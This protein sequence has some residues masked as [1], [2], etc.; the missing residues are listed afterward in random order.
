ME[1]VELRNE[2]IR[3][4]TELYQLNLE[5][6]EDTVIYNEIVKKMRLC[7]SKQKAITKEIKKLEEIIETEDAYSTILLIEGTDML[8]KVEQIAISNGMDKTDYRKLGNY[9]RW[10]DLERLVKNTIKLK[11]QYPGW[12]LKKITKLEGYDNMM[13]KNYYNFTFETP[14]GHFMS[15]NETE[16]Y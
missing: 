9:P 16:F 3:L 6:K 5:H 14:Q 4:R 2:I 12:V 13:P 11:K 10:V 8:L 7:E 15:L 1:F